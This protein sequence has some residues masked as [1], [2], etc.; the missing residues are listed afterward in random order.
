MIT[1]EKRKIGNEVEGYLVDK[2][3]IARP[4]IV[5]FRQ[6]ASRKGFDLKRLVPEFI[7]Q[8]CE[9]NIH[10]TS[11]FTTYR[12]MLVDEWG[13]LATIAESLGL[14]LLR[15][16][17]HPMLHRND[18]VYAVDQ[19]PRY[20]LLR[21][22]FPVA[23][24]TFFPASTHYHIECDRERLIPIFNLVCNWL[25]HILALSLN[26][27][28]FE[29]SPSGFLT[30]RIWMWKLFGSEYQ[31]E[32]LNGVIGVPPSFS[33][34]HAYELA[35]ESLKKSGRIHSEKDLWWLARPHEHENSKPTVEIRI[36]ESMFDVDQTVGIGAYLYGIVDLLDQS[37]LHHV[38]QPRFTPTQLFEDI[39]HVTKRGL[40][41]YVSHPSTG[42]RMPVKDSILKSL[43][44]IESQTIIRDQAW[45]DALHFVYHYAQGGLTVAERL[46][47]SL[48]NPL[49]GQEAL[50]QLLVM[51]GISK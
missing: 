22:H 16:G 9:Q 50:Q 36:A 10:P 37:I 19:H 49:S 2:D 21:E 44:E 29:G 25:P 11:S 39:E 28:Y 3:G 38:W 42:E 26:S 6:E 46:M 48:D 15:V 43:T 31:E 13:E 4:E 23:T 20:R 35:I 24:N 34:Q 41:A 45:S 33:T 12:A 32:S 40:H 17:V 27:P 18:I 8:L 14:S 5:R 7:K 47:G 30:Q 1:S 51:A